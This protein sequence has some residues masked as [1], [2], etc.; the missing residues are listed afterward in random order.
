MKAVDLYGHSL[1]PLFDVVP[2]FVVEMTAQIVSSEGSQIA[3]SI[4]EKLCLSNIVV[5][6][7]AMEKRRP[8]NASRS[9]GLH[10]SR[11]LVNAA[12]SVPRRLTTAT[13]SSS[14]DSVS[15][16]A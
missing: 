11:A 13:S 14:F 2:V 12:G 1:E 16:A 5:L 15:I 4:D 7:E 9:D 10:E 8:Q 6:G 3:A